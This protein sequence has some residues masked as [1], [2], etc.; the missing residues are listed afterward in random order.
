MTNV[1]RIKRRASGAAGSPTGL[2]NAE[3]AYNEVDDTL[4]YGKGTGGAGGTATTIEAIGGAGAFITLTG[5]QSISGNK[6]FSGV[7]IVPTPTENTHAATKAY[8]DNSLPSLTGGD[9]ITYNAGEISIDLAASSP[10]LVIDGS[11]KLAVSLSASHIPTLTSAKI[12]DFD[13]QV[14]TSRLDQMAAPTASVS[15]NSQKITNLAVP[16]DAADAA[17]KAYVDGLVSGGV[18][19]RGTVDAS[20]AA[21]STTALGDMYRVTV[22]GSVATGSLV[23]VGDYIVYNGTGWDKV[24]N[25]DPSV[26]AGTGITVTPTSDTSYQV[27]ISSSW[28]IDGGTF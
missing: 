1:I 4:Y 6:T 18:N 20:G 25:T 13:T 24:D 3:L 21:P 2:E 12:S 5:T 22:A 19:Y 16:T 9:G 11:G 14:R 17:T 27:A 7:V 26:S 15:L 10:G 28:V 23:N 8:V